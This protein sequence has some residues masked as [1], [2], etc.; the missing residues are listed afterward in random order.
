[1]RC[2]MTF[3]AGEIR[4]SA[5]SFS[6]S[7]R[8]RLR[9]PFY[10]RSEPVVVAAARGRS[11]GTSLT[12]PS[13]I[14]YKSGVVLLAQNRTILYDKSKIICI[15]KFH[16]ILFNFNEIPMTGGGMISGL[17]SSNELSVVYG[18]VM[19]PASIINPDGGERDVK[20]ADGG[21]SPTGQ[22]SC[23][24]KEIGGWLKCFDPF[25]HR[26]SG[27]IRV[28]NMCCCPSI[29]PSTLPISNGLSD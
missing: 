25:A 2:W 13:R 19:R 5:E 15:H 4:D 17:R 11:Q 9:A 26:G 20:V 1:M 21:G 24:D 18:G 28:V 29:S 16:Q 14:L 23:E 6:A 8:T 7:C 27:S 10:F 3:P 12:F 22:L